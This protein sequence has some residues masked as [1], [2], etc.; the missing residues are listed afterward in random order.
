MNIVVVTL[1]EPNDFRFH[2][3]KYKDIFLNYS[4]Y[5]IFNKYKINVDNQYIN[6]KYLYAKDNF[7]YLCNKVDLNKITTI[8][9]IYRNI[10]MNNYSIIGE[11]IVKKDEE[12]LFKE[13]LF[14]LKY[15]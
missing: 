3:E 13:P 14:Y 2:L 6:S 7:Y 8:Y 12:I 1:S 10:K 4:N 9:N 15:D 5:L 11:V